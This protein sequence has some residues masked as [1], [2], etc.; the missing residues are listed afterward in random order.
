MEYNN[1][2]IT[3]EELAKELHISK[4]KAYKMIQ[5]WNEKLKKLGYITIRGRISRQYYLEQLYGM[6]EGKEKK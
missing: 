2:F 4:G 6:V 1:I 3:A 5:A